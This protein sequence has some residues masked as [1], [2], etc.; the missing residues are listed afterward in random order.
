MCFIYLYPIL[1]EKIWINYI[2]NNHLRKFQIFMIYVADAY[3]NSD[4]D[5]KIY[6]LIF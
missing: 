4:D 2:S 5:M 1:Y 3:N 6:S